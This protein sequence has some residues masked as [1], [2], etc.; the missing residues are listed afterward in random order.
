MQTRFTATL[1]DLG[2][3]RINKDRSAT[4]RFETDSQQIAN[5]LAILSTQEYEELSVTLTVTN[6]CE[7]PNREATIV[8]TENKMEDYDGE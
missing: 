6:E 3:I 8:D 4:I 7:S 1:T 5:V 2:C